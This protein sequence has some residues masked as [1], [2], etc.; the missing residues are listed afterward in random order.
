MQSSLKKAAALA[1][2]ALAIMRAFAGE[3]EAE[4]A[5]SYQREIAP[6]LH[7]RCAVCHGE[8]T[9]KGRYRLDTFAQMR[10]AGDSDAAPL[11]AGKPVES[12]L[13]GR[14]VETDP[15][16]RMPQK[17]D[18]LPATEIALVQ[19]WIAEG[20]RND[21]GSDERPLAA[22]VR[23][24]LLL[25]AP[26]KYAWP[27]PVTALAFSPD[28]TLLAAPGYYEV[29]LW[30]VDTGTLARR[31]G[32]LPGRIT[33][34]AWNRQTGLLAV[35]GGSPSQWGGVFLVDPANAFAVRLL[36][37]LPDTALHVAFSPDGKLLAVAG[38][39]RAIRLFDTASGKQ[40]RLLRQHSD[41]VQTV[42]FSKDGA[43]LLSA[44]RDRM[45]RV[46]STDSGDATAVYDDHAAPVLAAVFSPDGAA[47]YSVARGQPVHG[48]EIAEGK[49]RGQFTDAGREVQALLPARF[50]L[51]TGSIDGLVRLSEYRARGVTMTFWGHRDCVESL[52]IAPT[53]P[54]FASGA[55][56][57]E[58][59]V[60]DLACETCVR[61]FVTSP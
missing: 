49:P 9:A 37:D 26:A 23:E 54:Y 22:I 53:G 14:L 33:T 30:D 34:L 5:V 50:G 46:F 60:W 35:G 3:L 27:A 44:G 16:D 10:K 31:I 1:L 19:R 58:V 38:G 8:E 45:A 43:R 15:H 61:R 40:T 2:C 11:V 48:W 32:G 24:S 12:E 25:P 47:A 41:L 55:H 7:R 52:A 39:D 28:G 21:A 20:A 13:Y 4:K 56:D 42:A 59:C 29:T 18:A 51:L 6:I 36:A 17:A 57:G